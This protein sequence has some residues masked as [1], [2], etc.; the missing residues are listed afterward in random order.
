M[1]AEGWIPEIKEKDTN[2]NYLNI[3]VT[4]KMVV[5]QWNL[6]IRNQGSE[7]RKIESLKLTKS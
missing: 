4:L 5:E 7:L 6:D 1:K 3:L 2:W